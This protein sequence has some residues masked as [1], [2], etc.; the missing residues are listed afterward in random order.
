MLPPL[1]QT[2]DAMQAPQNHN[3]PIVPWTHTSAPDTQQCPWLICTC[4]ANIC[5]VQTVKNYEGLTTTW[6]TFKCT[7]WPMY[8]EPFPREGPT[9]TAGPGKVSKPD[10][11]R[12]SRSRAF[13]PETHDLHKKNAQTDLKDPQN[14]FEPNF[15]KRQLLFFGWNLTL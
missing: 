11:A 6:K 8:K 10:K 14:R 15:I 7:R 13:L 9:A 2:H 4:S 5:W 1:M 3:R 12:F